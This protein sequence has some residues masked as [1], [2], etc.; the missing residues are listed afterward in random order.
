MYLVS[1]N[2]THHLILS[3]SVSNSCKWKKDDVMW[4]HFSSTPSNFSVLQKLLCNSLQNSN[5]TLKKGALPYLTLME[6]FYL[7]PT[8][9]PPL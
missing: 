5:I 7:S 3:D 2:F 6:N 9:H 4:L 1:L 8:L